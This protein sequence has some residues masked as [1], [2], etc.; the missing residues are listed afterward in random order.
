ME[1]LA[2][3]EVLQFHLRAHYQ[4]LNRDLGGRKPQNDLDGILPYVSGKD[5][6]PMFV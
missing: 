1:G 3:S 6:D 2:Y 4:G 5:K